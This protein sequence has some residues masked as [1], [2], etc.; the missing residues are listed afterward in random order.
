MSA[1]EKRSGQTASSERWQC[2][3]PFQYP[4]KSD[5]D[6][7]KKL[8]DL[9]LEKDRIRCESWKDEVQNLLI[10]AG[11]FSG[12]LTAFV[13]QSYPELQPDQNEIM[14]S[15]LA[16]IST[17]LANPLNN[18]QASPQLPIDMALNAG[19]P[20]TSA[21][22]VN[23]FWLISLVLSLTTAL[24]SIVSLQWLTE[25]QQYPSSLSYKEKFA[26]LNM[27]MESLDA[28]HVPAIFASL[29][30]LLQA[31]LTL[32]FIG[33]IDFL[34][35]SSSPV[36]IPVSISIGIPFAFS[37]LTTVIPG[38]QM[39]IFCLPITDRTN[40][41][42]QQAPYRSTQARLFRQFIAISE[43][44]FS[45]CAH[46]NYTVYRL[47]FSLRRLRSKRRGSQEVEAQKML[48]PI[49]SLESR[50]ITFKFLIRETVKSL[51]RSSWLAF[52]E[53]WLITRDAYAKSIFKK[54][55]WLE[56]AYKTTLDRNSA[57]LYDLASGI[58]WAVNEHG[59]LDPTIIQ[60]AYSSVE[61]M[62]VSVIGDKDGILKDPSWEAPPNAYLQCLLSD[63]NLAIPTPTFSSML[64]KPPTEFL[65]EEN[66]FILLSHLE[67][68]SVPLFQ[69]FAELHVRLLNYLYPGKPS[70]TIWAPLDQFPEYPD[71][72]LLY[73]Y[74]NSEVIGGKYMV[75]SEGAISEQ[76]SL[77]IEA[78]LGLFADHAVDENA[79]LIS[80]YGRQ[81]GEIIRYA[82]IRQSSD[83]V[84]S[85]M[86]LL[87][88]RI[89]ESVASGAFSKRSDILFCISC[90]YA[91]SV[92]ISD[93]WQ[94]EF[95]PGTTYSDNRDVIAFL[96]VLLQYLEARGEPDPT[97][98]ARFGLP[99]RS[100]LK[101]W[102]FLDWRGSD[103]EA[104]EKEPSPLSEE[105]TNGALTP[106]SIIQSVSYELTPSIDSE[107]RT[108]RQ[109]GQTGELRMNPD[110]GNLAKDWE[111][112]DPYTYPITVEGD[113]WE[114]LFK[115]RLQKDSNRCDSWREEVQNLLIFA[116]LFSA[117]VTAFVALS[118][119]N[120]QPDRDEI[121]IKLLTQIASNSDNSLNGTSNSNSVA[122][123]VNQ[124]SLSSRPSS[125]S[126][127]VNVS[128]FISLVLSLATAIIGIVSLQWLR[129]HQQYPATLTSRQKFAL[130]NMRIDGLEAWH[131]PGIFSSLPLLLQMALAFFLA[132][133][134]DFLLD[135]SLVVAIPV[136]IAISIPFVFLIYTT[137]IPSLHMFVFC[138]PLSYGNL[139][140][141]H[142]APYKSPQSSH[143][144]HFFTLFWPA[145]RFCAYSSRALY[146]FFGASTSFLQRCLKRHKKQKLTDVRGPKN[147]SHWDM[148][149]LV[150]DLCRTL[151]SSTWQSF[152]EQWLLLRNAYAK[153]AFDNEPDVQTLFM[154][155]GNTGSF[156]DL[157][158]GIRTT[159]AQYGKSDP[160]IIRSGYLGVQE[161]TQ[162]IVGKTSSHS[163]NLSYNRYFQA[164]LH[165]GN[166]TKPAPTFC[167]LVDH[168]SYEFMQDENKFIFLSHHTSPSP[169]IVQ[170]FAEL[171][172]RIANYLYPRRL[173]GPF[174]AI[175][176]SKKYPTYPDHQI[177][178]Y[179][180]QK[181]P[182]QEKYDP[183]LKDAYDQLSSFVDAF[184]H[185]VADPDL[186]DDDVLK[187][188][189]Q[190]VGKI[191]E[192]AAFRQSLTRWAPTMEFLTSSLRHFISEKRLNA[193]SDLLFYVTA[194]YVRLLAIQ[195]DSIEN[196]GQPK[197]ASRTDAYIP[198]LHE[199]LEA[200]RLPDIDLC[201]KLGIPHF[202]DDWWSFMKELR[203]RSRDQRRGR[204]IDRLSTVR[205][206]YPATA[207]VE[208]GISEV[209]Q[210]RVVDYRAE[211]DV[212][213]LGHR[214]TRVTRR[215]M[216]RFNLT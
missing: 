128:W 13:I 90:F 21:I 172:V 89:N 17:Q 157:T 212:D 5:G 133:L 110:A 215:E 79:L 193:R 73:H 95:W 47:F 158:R 137:I 82:A 216:A 195:E 33:L 105:V 201:R 69:H 8:L 119:P 16:R 45:L 40:N 53:E 10:F 7:W 80:S 75:C 155:S 41:T 181:N 139:R 207:T 58:L 183:F 156:Y 209:S 26:L 102:N 92:L 178:M 179:Y 122:A 19:P 147:T 153:S 66:Y 34:I 211:P 63:G 68:P 206:N 160:A 77:L 30:I 111:C 81:S 142:Q 101:W 121:I 83:S 200:R 60:C 104:E 213:L 20:S 61:D 127:R 52:D 191:F 159:T 164:L 131:V 87:S 184:L 91:R 108:R 196:Y 72:F 18:T 67:S 100:D 120:L 36:A 99:D 116:G 149:F 96:P 161:M 189:G 129:E 117:V 177:Y 185:V 98:L 65:R 180:G 169:S 86:N 59:N 130:L 32:F 197:H 168:A 62:T 57:M 35:A 42:P 25:H 103:E 173:E 114:R 140:M 152:D 167:E 64:E 9:R 123:V 188:H 39:F 50:L 125:S 154:A 1:A 37:I 145:F 85:M 165:F 23:I 84:A 138:F 11:L 141:P 182:W 24:I 3:D 143:F 15:L 205:I 51:R 109:T 14:I 148:E 6:H 71:A 202:S 94:F 106:V 162:D 163:N 76:F 126:F 171:H 44:A 174:R 192:Y 118:Y 56:L 27:R 187:T 93:P 214:I 70:I 146:R 43:A 49:L 48:R 135:A 210:G 97:L 78:Y 54:E 190:K 112:G 46:A 186:N 175:S 198:A 28:W 115:A 132:G 124:A 38:L 204:T 203:G 88:M 22:R 176:A 134:I 74:G 208:E 31:A 170:H 4:I 136:I 55:S 151:N 113:H 12:V 166:Y 29:P 144:R 107:N 2:G 199:Y 150:E 194:S